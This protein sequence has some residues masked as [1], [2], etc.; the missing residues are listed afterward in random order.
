MKKFTKV[1]ISLLVVIFSFAFNAQKAEAQTYTNPTTVTLIRVASDHTKAIISWSGGNH[2]EYYRYQVDQSSTMVILPGPPPQELW[3]GILSVGL[4]QV[5]GTVTTDTIE[6]LEDVTYYAHVATYS[7]TLGTCVVPATPSTPCVPISDPSVGGIV[8]NN[9]GATRDT[10]VYG[11]QITLNLSAYVGTI[12]NWEIK[13]ND[14]NWAFTPV[15]GSGYA[16][17]PALAGTW[18]YRAIVK[19]GNSPEVSS[20]EFTLMVNPKVL[21]VT[22][23]SVVKDYNGITVQNFTVKYDGFFGSENQSSLTGTLSFNGSTAIGATD[24]GNYTIVPSG[25]ISSEDKYEIIYHTG[26]L[27]I[28]PATVINVTNTSDNNVGSLRKA[29]KNLKDGGMIVFSS[30]IDGQTINLLSGLVIDRN[31]TI[32]NFNHVIGLTLSGTGDNITINTGKC[33]TLGTGSK[34]TIPAVKNNAGVGGLVLESG[35][36]LIQNTIDLQAT[37][38]KTLNSGWHLFGSP[39]KQGMGNTLS[40]LT[41][42]GGSTQ[43]KP[44]TNGTN[45]Q[46]NITSPLYFLQPTVGYAVCPSIGFTAKLTGTLWSSGLQAPYTYN[47]PLVYN[48]TGATQ[49]WNLVANPF[50]CYLDWRALGKTSLS[51][52]LYIWDNSLAVGP[53]VTNTTYFRTYNA[54]NGVGVPSGTLP[55]IAPLQGC[56]VRAIYTNPSISIPTSAR[57][58]SYNNFYKDFNNTEILVRLKTETAMGYDELVLCK[59]PDAKLGYEEFDSEKLFDGLPVAMFS[60]TSSGEKLVINTINDTNIVIPITIMGSVGDKAKITAFDLESSIPVYLEDRL[61]GQIISLSENS[62]YNFDFPTDE[63]VGRFFIRFNNPNAT[64]SASDIN[65][66]QTGQ[67]LNIVAQTGEE[68]QEVEVFTLT[69]ACVFKA[70]PSRSNTFVSSFN[71]PQAIYLVRVK[72]SL[73]MQTKKLNW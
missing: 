59:N 48:G 2:G 54:A 33:L 1:A 11:N 73:T 23:D 66:F 39:F 51:T 15:V 10:I 62:T 47:I 28:N 30:S 43:L 22:A 49:S 20:S 60:Q 8:T 67:Q 29:I 37:V 50:P 12:Q 40:C 9:S 6:G 36:T 41:P 5:A 71:F 27:K 26:I 31:V 69:G 14:E 24:V 55:Y 17:W 44:Y 4:T 19:N 35:V 38:K 53:P 45:W 21:N 70:T 64:L 7:T 68:I 57:T 52:S 13:L 58:N 16:E 61:K 72:T 63:V 18:H 34:F 25:L 46:A 42:I 56:F 3:G 65:V 32:N